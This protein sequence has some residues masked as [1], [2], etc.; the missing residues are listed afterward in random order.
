MAVFPA[1]PTVSGECVRSPILEA[2]VI[3]ISEVE[4]EFH[5]RILEVWKEFRGRISDLQTEFCQVN[6]AP[7]GVAVPAVSLPI[8]EMQDQEEWQMVSTGAKRRKALRAP[9]RVKTVNSFSVLE[10]MEEEGEKA[11]GDEVKK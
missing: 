5:Q 2:F 8:N 1:F 3:K 10:G 4:A 9:H 11:G 6:S 7:E